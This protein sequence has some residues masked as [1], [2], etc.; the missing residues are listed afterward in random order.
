MELKILNSRELKE[1][2]KIIEKQYGI[3]EKLDYVFLLSGKDDVYVINDSV[4]NLDLDSIKINTIGIYIGE[5]KFDT[6]RPS[7][8]GSQ[9]FGPL[10]K[11]NILEVDYKVMK[12]WMYGLDIPCKEELEG[13]VMIKSGT[14]YIGSGKYKECA[15]K[16]EISGT[17]TSGKILNHVPKGRRIHE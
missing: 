6:F 4:K 11:K 5:N 13:Y 7:I 8:E 9:I 1:L 10:A 16:S 12:M 17:T 14:D 15:Q 3:T 2:R